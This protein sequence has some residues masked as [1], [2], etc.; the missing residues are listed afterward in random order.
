MPGGGRAGGKTDGKI[1]YGYRRR[2]R[3]AVSAM[4]L[5]RRNP[6]P[7]DQVF[8]TVSRRTDILQKDFAGGTVTAAGP[9]QRPDLL[10]DQ[11][12]IFRCKG[13]VGGIGFCRLFGR[14]LVDKKIEACYNC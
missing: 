5:L 3:R 13:Q 1:E 8:Q 14:V 9:D 6:V 10:A 11:I 2:R 7:D 12:G 4:G